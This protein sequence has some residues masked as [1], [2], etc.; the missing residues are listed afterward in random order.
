MKCQIVQIECRLVLILVFLM[1]LT[2]NI[3]L[4]NNVFGQFDTLHDQTLFETTRR[5]SGFDENPHITVGDAPR[6]MTI[7]GRTKDTLTLYVANSGELGMS[8]SSNPG[9]DSVSIIQVANNTKIEDIPVGGYPRAIAGFITAYVANFESNTVSV[10]DTLGN[11]TRRVQEIPV[12]ES[13]IDIAVVSDDEVYVA[14]FESNT[15]SVIDTLENGTRRVQEIP[16]GEL[17]ID[18]AVDLNNYPVYVVNGGSDNVSVSV[19]DTL[20]NGTRGVVQE[21][22]VG[23]VSIKDMAVNQISDTVYLAREDSNTVSV[24]DTLE[25][26]TRGVVQEI[27]VGESPIDIA[28]DMIFDRLYVANFESNT[29]S[30]IDTLENGTRGVVQE[31]PVGEGPRDIAVDPM[32]TDTVYVANHESNSVSVIDARSNRVVAG[33]TFNVNPF[34]SGYIACEDLTTPSGED[35]TPPSPTGQYT[36]VYSGTQ[37]TATPNQGFEFSSWEENLGDNSTQ[38]I[39]VSRP[40]SSLDSFLEFL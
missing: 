23:E 2:V 29:V 6:V 33:V 19:I 35:L 34:N 17:P 28:V 10:I 7:G 26:G 12:G 24:I 4:S 20:E 18:I 38:P 39:S 13:P 3:T 9:N 27:P 21:I 11:V 14:N 32:F 8:G 15:V 1:T 31:I 37:C 16:V 5:T 40:T 36:Y 25:N 22:P 30:V